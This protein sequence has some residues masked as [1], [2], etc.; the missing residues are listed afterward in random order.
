VREPGG[1]SLDLLET[2]EEKSGVI[3]AA[4]EQRL[5]CRLW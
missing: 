3:P 1:D 2:L 5:A 4:R